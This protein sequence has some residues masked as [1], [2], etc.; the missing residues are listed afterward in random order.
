[1]F[2]DPNFVPDLEGIDGRTGAERKHTGVDHAAIEGIER[3]QT[4][5]RA[6]WH[7]DQAL[8]R[9][10]GRQPNGNRG[11][12]GNED[13]KQSIHSYLLSTREP[14]A[15]SRKND[16]LEKQNRT[17]RKKT[18]ALYLR[19]AASRNRPRTDVRF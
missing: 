11:Q 5:V 13:G 12:S 6:V 18:A 8:G 10:V 15:S 1:L 2:R 19:A 4:V 3:D 14:F 9:G 17:T 16:P 7:K